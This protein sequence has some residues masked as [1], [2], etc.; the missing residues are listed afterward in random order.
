MTEPSLLLYF[1]YQ[2]LEFLNVQPTS[3]F[4]YSSTG[5][6]SSE[7]ILYYSCFVVGCFFVVFLR[8][9]RTVQ[10]LTSSVPSIFRTLIS[11]LNFS[12]T[13]KRSVS[14]FYYV[15]SIHKLLFPGPTLVDSFPNYMSFINS[16]LIP[17]LLYS[18]Y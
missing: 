7:K 13:V 1:E 9:H 17:I 18:L 16:I 12:P 2:G 6:L 14:I 15:R 3:L 11:T 10:G 5:N 8:C 4:V